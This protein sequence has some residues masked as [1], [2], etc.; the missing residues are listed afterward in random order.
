[1]NDERIARMRTLLQAELSAQQIEITDDS[2]H[3]AGHLDADGGG[4]FSVRIISTA[5]TGLSAVQR[6]RRVFSVLAGMIP[7]EIHALSIQAHTPDEVGV[8]A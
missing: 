5:F 8:T 1:M 6:H 4:H 7:N 3:H 2:H